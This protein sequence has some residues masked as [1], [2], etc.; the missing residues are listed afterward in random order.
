MFPTS[1]KR[2]VLP[3]CVPGRRFSSTW[4]RRVRCQ[5]QRTLFRHTRMPLARRK[6]RREP[7]PTLVRTN[8]VDE[9]GAA[10]QRFGCSPRTARATCSG[11]RLVERRVCQVGHIGHVERSQ[12][13][14]GGRC[15]GE[16][17]FGLARLPHRCEHKQRVVLTASMASV[18]GNQRE[19]DDNHLWS[20]EDFNDAPSSAYSLSKTRAEECAWEFIASDAVAGKVCSPKRK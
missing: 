4:H 14:A 15:V 18:C 3:N 7:P 6:W 12:G 20:P 19:T 13:R 16:S 1:C 10:L 11:K 17:A 8:C 9:R 2:P 5:S